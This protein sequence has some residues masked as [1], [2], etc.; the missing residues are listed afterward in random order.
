MELSSVNRL[1]ALAQELGVRETKNVARPEAAWRD[2]DVVEAS[3]KRND[4]PKGDDGLKV[5]LSE[6]A[7]R[8]AEGLPATPTTP[9][10]STT[11]PAT[12]PVEFDDSRR[13]ASAKPGH[14]RRSTGI[15]AYESN[16]RAITGER[17]RVIA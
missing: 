17:I 11:P 15:A 16:A 14:F 1:L 3:L 9:A 7:S 12:A 2:H 5:S 10:T 8:L 13:P 6:A 4:G